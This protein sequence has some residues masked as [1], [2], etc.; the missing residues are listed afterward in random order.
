MENSEIINSFS[1]YL[2]RKG[3][4]KSTLLAYVKDIEQLCLN[5]NKK[6]V[7]ELSESDIKQCLDKWHKN[8]DFS[9]KTVSRKLNSIRTFYSYLS[10]KRF[11]TTNPATNIHHPKFR[12]EKPRVLSKVEYLT[13]KDNCSDNLKLY[14]IVELLLQTGMRIGEL[15]RLKI[16]DI[17]VNNSTLHISE[18]STIETRTVPL[19]NKTLKSLKLYLGTLERKNKDIALFS[20]KNGKPIEVR[21][22]RASI[23][24]IIKKSK[25]KD[26]SVNDIRNTFIVYQLSKGMSI[27]CLAEIVGHKSTATTIRYLQLLPKQYKDKGIR[28]IVEL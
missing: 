12:T 9:V 16:N 21:N 2:K 17:N 24:K 5:T 23:D 8:G 4:A 3:K 7:I 27:D 22:I 6:S 11:V 14:T 1:T 18:F 15:S 19:N 13:L 26:T 25:I 28:E 20:T 10:E